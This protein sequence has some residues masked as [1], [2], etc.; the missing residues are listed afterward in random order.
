MM[1]YQ[2]NLLYAQE[3]SKKIYNKRVKLKNN[4]VN[5]KV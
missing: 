5:K 2:Q 3:L 1:S 4:L